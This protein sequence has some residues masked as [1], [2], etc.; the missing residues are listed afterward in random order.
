MKCSRNVVF[1]KQP[2]VLIS[3]VSV[4]DEDNELLKEKAYFTSSTYYRDFPV[5]SSEVAVDIALHT[6]RYCIGCAQSDKA[7]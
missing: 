2:P 3:D 5:F 7:Q 4:I 1:L 6:T